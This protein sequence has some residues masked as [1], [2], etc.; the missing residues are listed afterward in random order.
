MFAQ[1][2]D[3]GDDDQTKQTM[4]TVLSVVQ[5]HFTETDLFECIILTL[6]SIEPGTERSHQVPQGTVVRFVLRSGHKSIYAI[7]DGKYHQKLPN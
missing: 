2:N 5:V 6:A 1:H 4:D 7:F 3:D